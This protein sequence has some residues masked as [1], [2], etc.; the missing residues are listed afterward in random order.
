[1]MLKGK[2]LLLAILIV[3]FLLIAGVATILANLG[4][5]EPYNRYVTKKFYGVIISYE[6][7]EEGL[8]FDLD[9]LGYTSHRK[10]LITDYTMYA[11]SEIEQ[12][13]MDK[14]TGIQ[15]LIISEFWTQDSPSSY[16][17]TLIEIEEPSPSNN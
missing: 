3:I 17:V 13:I 9:V 5:P 16:P 10:F 4:K 1:M 15:V 11:G 7:T 14:V 12:A 6:D 8:V 2:K